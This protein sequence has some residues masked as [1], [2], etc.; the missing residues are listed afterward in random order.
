MS[1]DPDLGRDILLPHIQV[2]H[3][4]ESYILNCSL[5]L[6]GKNNYVYT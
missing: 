2:Y 1:S 5:R 3:N 6:K 4:G